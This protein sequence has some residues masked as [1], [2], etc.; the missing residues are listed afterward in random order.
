MPSIAVNVVRGIVLPLGLML[1]TSYMTLISSIVPGYD[2]WQ[3]R[4]VL[5]RLGCL[6]RH[7]YPSR[8]NVS[9][10]VSVPILIPPLL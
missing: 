8:E 10:L 1:P 6:V 7:L 9:H 2:V 4:N 3:R 5:W